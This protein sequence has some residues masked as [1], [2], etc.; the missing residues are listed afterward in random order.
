V[1]INCSTRVSNELGAG[2]PQAASVAVRVALC[3]VLAEGII[4]VLLMILLRKIWGTLYSSETQVVDYVA[5]MM[6]ILAICSFLDGIQSVLSGIHV[7]FLPNS[8]PTI[9]FSVTFGIFC[10]KLVEQ[11]LIIFFSNNMTKK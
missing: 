10:I 1:T 4:V 3:L 7:N 6:P 5:A 11:V 8:I 9:S 2:N